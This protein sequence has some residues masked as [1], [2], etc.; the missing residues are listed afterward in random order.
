MT[1]TRRIGRGDVVTAVVAFGARAATLLWANG[2]FPPAA[3]GFYYH[4]LAVRIANGLGSTWLWPDGKITYAAHYPVGYPALLALAYK[5]GGESA[6]AGGWF[7]AV[8]GT[9]AAIAAYRLALEVTSR[10]WA[11]VA[12]IGVALHPGLVMYTPAIMTE[13][14][15][16]A[17]LIVAAWAASR[18]SR[19]GLLAS[20]LVMG[21]ATLVRPQSLLLAPCFG[22]A[23]SRAGASL[24]ERLQR[25]VVATALALAVCAPWTARNCIRM[26]Q[27]ALVSFNGGWNLLIGASDESNGS[28]SPVAVPE[29]CRTVWDEAEKDACFAREARRLIAEN[30]ARW[31][32]LIPARLAATFDYAGAPGFY[33]HAS[34]AEAFGER[35]KIMLGFVET[36]YERVF[37]LGALLGAAMARGPRKRARAFVAAISGVLLFQV[38][39]YLAVLG[40]AV[41]LGLLGKRLLDGA[42]LPA[43]TFF[44]VVATAAVH[45]VFFGSGRYSMV[46]FPFVTAF[47]SVSIGLLPRL[48]GGTG[49]RD[50]RSSEEETPRC[51]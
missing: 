18:R 25:V 42:A 20:G 17:L 12:G 36:A 51:P 1:E 49:E 5:L 39:A 48:T 9:M 31:V 38:H 7:N 22:F 8:L 47:G 11:L 29:A 34:N 30:P 19:P 2:R 14:V 10:R 28:W 33:L 4:T 41:S 32:A 45:G 44:T 3:D 13:G 35:A 27:C 21:M 6:A 43:A 46:I 16:A 15:T 37:F 24:G 23:S 50:T 40:L 26:S